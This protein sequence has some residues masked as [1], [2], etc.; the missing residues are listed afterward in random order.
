MLRLEDHK[1]RIDLSV[2]DNKRVERGR[3]SVRGRTLGL[4]VRDVV[5][6]KETK[7]CCTLILATRVYPILLTKI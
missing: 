5:N 6:G 4:A 2:T 7:P 3:D 1:D